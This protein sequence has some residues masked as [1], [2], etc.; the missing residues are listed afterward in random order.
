M[1]TS[2]IAPGRTV[3]TVASARRLAFLVDGADYFHEL[4]RV[5]PL[6]EKEIWIVGWDFDPDIRL[7]PGE[8]DA[9]RLADMLERQLAAKPELKVRILVWA[10]GPLY[11]GKSL[12]LFRRRGILGHERVRFKFDSR[13]PFRGSHHQKIVV[14]DDALAFIGGIDLTAR[15]WDDS[16]HLPANPLRLNP[17][18]TTYEAVHDLQVM[19]DGPAARRISDLARRR[20]LRATGREPGS[21]PE[22]VDRWPPHR[23]ADLEDCRVGLSL[24]EPG[25]NGEASKRQSVLLA[26]AA[27]RKG[28]RHIYIEAQYLASFG[29]AD[30]LAERL[31]QED[32]P[33][34]VIVVTR[35]SHGFIEKVIMGNNR[36]RIIRRLKRADVNDRL[37][38]M[39]AVVPDE[40]GGAHEVLVHSKLLIVD[41]EFLRV[42]SSNL[43]HRS[44][45]LDTEA[46]LAIE[47]AGES[48]R[49]AIAALRHRLLAEHMGTAPEAVAATFAATGSLQKTIEA[50]NIGA[51][52]LRHFDIEVANGAVHPVP[53][54]AIIDPAKPFRP[55][56]ALRRF[57]ARLMALFF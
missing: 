6:A 20:W 11:S 33:E 15:R 8:E 57:G 48:E 2:I 39:Y 56:V 53:G 14:I 3:W 32:G 4:S 52:G 5:L 34:I 25:I 19:L 41:D 46:D 27:I 18:G 17:D 24:T 30:A 23:G 36:D 37:W 45:G 38:V 12:K 44:E 16:R 47:A 51:R 22:A 9:C 55:A 13:H 42:G 21:R 31:A 50:H 28:R 35:I 10:L 7:R 1:R 43:N 40:T 29:I 54:T 49:A 26:R